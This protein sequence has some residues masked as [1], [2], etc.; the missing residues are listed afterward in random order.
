MEC[1]HQVLLD[2]C[3]RGKL[4]NQSVDY[5]TRLNGLS[6]T[7]D[8]TTK[9]IIFDADNGGRIEHIPFLIKTIDRLGISAVI[10][11]DKIGLKK[12]PFENQKDAKQDTIE[13]FCKKIEKANDSKLS[14]SLMIVS[15]IESLILNTGM[16][17]ALNRAEAYS[18]AGAYMIV[19]HSKKKQPDEVIEFAKKF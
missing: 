14:E 1:G 3:L 9:P 2:S 10:I 5:S 13:N 4:D 18:Q 16:K 6:E 8:A 17:D 11:E 7:L 19:I 15:R 12:F